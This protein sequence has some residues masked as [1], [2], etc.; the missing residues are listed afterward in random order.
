M[1]SII[2]MSSS[3]LAHQPFYNYFSKPAAKDTELV[4]F[5]NHTLIYFSCFIYCNRYICVY[6]FVFKNPILQDE[7]SGMSPGLS[8]SSERAVDIGMT[9][10]HHPHH[11]NHQHIKHY[12][13]KIKISEMVYVFSLNYPYKYQ[14]FF[15]LVIYICF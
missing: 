3:V 14:N 12:Q 10:P 15:K 2:V 4:T 6:V 7:R 13:V 9:G 1:S 8:K 11:L 5:Y